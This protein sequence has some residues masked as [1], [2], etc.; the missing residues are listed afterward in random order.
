MKY[1]AKKYLLSK[2]DVFIFIAEN[3]AMKTASTY[4]LSLPAPNRLFARLVVCIF[5]LLYNSDIQDI[6]PP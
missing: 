6:T 5:K 1:H 4:P 3:K 2:K